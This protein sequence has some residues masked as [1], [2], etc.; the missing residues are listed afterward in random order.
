MKRAILLFAILFV[1]FGPAVL[2]QRE[3][4]VQYPTVPGTVA[5]TTVEGTQLPEYVKYIFNFAIALAGLVAFGVL[6]WGGIR[7]L[8]SAGDPSKLSDTKDQIFAAFL[9]LIILLSSY[10]ILTTINPQLVIFEIKEI[11]GVEV[12]PT[13]GVWL[14]KTDVNLESQ[15]PEEQQKIT[16]ECLSLTT[17]MNLPDEF[18]N[19]IKNVYFAGSQYGVIL[20]EDENFKDDCQVFESPGAV[21]ISNPSSAIPFI[22]NLSPQG[23][24]ILY[25]ETDFNEGLEGKKSQGPYGVGLYAPD[26]SPA[27]SIKVEGN[28]PFIIALGKDGFKGGCE[29]FAESHRSLI[30]YEVGKFC[31]DGL[32]FWKRIPCVKAMRVV[33]GVIY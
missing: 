30:E 17:K 23:G 16:K 2:A 5:P 10:L 18:N 27:R 28:G 15:D 20:H 26:M 32:Q 9:G 33:G 11:T 25:E 6:V 19:K 3:L 21:T 7:Y 4:E 14:C 12:R 8:T 22:K 31:I 1:L 24:I 29:V 13:P